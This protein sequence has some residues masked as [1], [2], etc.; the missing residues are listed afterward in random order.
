MLYRN[1]SRGA[2]SR[3]A[4]GRPELDAAL[5]LPEK[6]VAGRKTIGTGEQSGCDFPVQPLRAS[7]S[8]G[9]S[10]EG[11]FERIS[12]KLGGLPGVVG[13]SSPG[14]RKMVFALP[15]VALVSTLPKRM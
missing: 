8:A 4:A 6:Q 14:S 2:C 13:N 3:S 1:V 7:G 12:A 10:C 9:Q 11:L 5:P 15:L